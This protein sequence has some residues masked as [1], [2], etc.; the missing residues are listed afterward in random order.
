MKLQEIAVKLGIKLIGNGNRDI[1][2]VTSPQDAQPS[3]IC[4][5]WEKRII[6]ELDKSVAIMTREKYF[7]ENRD[8]L[9]CETPR[10]KLAE[11]L[12]LF[13]KEVKIS[14][15]D[16]LAFV[17]ESA[18]VAPSA[19][20]C[21]YA[22][23]GEN[24]EIG[25]NTVIEPNA[26]IMNDVKIGSNCLIH[27]GAVIGTDGFG[28]ERTETGIVKIPQIGGVK[29]GDNVEIGACTTVDRGAMGDTEIGSGTKI[30]NHV[31]IGHNVKVGKSCIICS[32]SGIAG[33]SII[34]DNVT[35]SVQAGVNDHVRVGAGTIIAGRTG[36]TS[37]IPAGSVVSGFPARNH[38]DAKRAL[39]LSADLPSIVKR[40]RRLERLVN[41]AAD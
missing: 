31:Q 41:E 25:E 29:I 12:A 6:P 34:E 5:L 30:D 18:K 20:I 1:T 11:L 27:S 37:D 40:L 21:A 4:V 9:A 10:L 17:A 16:A 26:V 2:G 38:N 24:C 13:T 7:D 35:I 8:G 36:V 3:K 39:M 15:V 32:M 14:G 19:H 28:F 23:I 22:Y 33:S